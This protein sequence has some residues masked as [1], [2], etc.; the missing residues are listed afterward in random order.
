MKKIIFEKSNIFG[1]GRGGGAWLA[2]QLEKGG[3][4][5]RCYT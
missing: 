4:E 3:S 1:W 5:G 2:G